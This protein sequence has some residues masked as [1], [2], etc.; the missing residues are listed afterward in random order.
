M[1]S[2]INSTSPFD[3]LWMPFSYYNDTLD[4]PPIVIEKG[5]GVWI[6]DKQGKKYLD[7]IGSWWVSILGHN[8]PYITDAVRNQLD[9][10]EHVMM[11]GFIAEPAQRLSQ[12]LSKILPDELS[13]IFYSD[14][15]STSVEVAMKIALQYHALRGEERSAFVSFEGGYHGD[16]L[17]AMSVGM[18]PQYHTLFHERFK[19]HLF[20]NSPYCY[21]CPV[22]RISES[23]NCECM[24][25]LEEI[26]Q[27][28]SGSIAAC[29]FEPMVQGAAGMRVYPSK[30]LKRIF[31]LCRKY[32]VL[33][34][35]D[36][37]AMGFGRTGKLF[38]CEH[39]G[40]VPD[41]MCIAKGLTGGYLPLSATVVREFIFDEFKGDYKSDRIFNHGHTFTGNPL[42]AAAACATIDLITSMHIPES[43]ECKIGY[44][45]EKL[46][47]FK[48]F[49]IVGDIRAL[50]MCAAIELVE[51]KS[52]KKRLPAESRFSFTLSRKAVER[53]LIIRPLGDI[54][55]FMPPFIITENEIDFVIDTTVEVLQ[56]TIDEL[57]PHL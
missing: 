8:H 53:G 40:E 47:I 44:L 50:G 20:A 12:M 42:A 7:A 48:K 30:V 46:S 19:K 18:I 41:I 15:G 22:N 28:N 27:Q 1:H 13:R 14:D 49:D 4:F 56:E 6:I 26:L 51:D 33:T 54:I 21:R 31:T 16:T 11:A 32:N 45:H 43:I 39:A 35:A 17:G 52:S 3:K 2:A 24:D 29:L 36:E 5:Q 25:S 23:C 55:Y 37:V 57:L 10:I 34:I 9:K 38:A